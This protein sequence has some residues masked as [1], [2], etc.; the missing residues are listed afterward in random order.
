MEYKYKNT[1]SKYKCLLMIIHHT[2][3]RKWQ[4]AGEIINTVIEYIVTLIPAGYIRN[5][6]FADVIFKQV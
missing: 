5:S 1:G 6:N 3:E 2:K 4:S